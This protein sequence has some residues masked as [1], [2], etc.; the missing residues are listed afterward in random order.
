MFSYGLLHM[1]TPV[2]SK[3]QE[4]TLT[5]SVLRLDDVKS[6]GQYEQMLSVKEIHTVGKPRWW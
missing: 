1:D 2:L 5:N 6:N 3:Q 4:F